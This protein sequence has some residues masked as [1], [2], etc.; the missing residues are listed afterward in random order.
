MGLNAGALFTSLTM[1]VMVSKALSTGEPLSLTRIVT[2]FVL[3]PCASVGVQL[4]RP[5]VGL[6][7]A[8]DGAPGSR[9]KVSNCAGRSGS[10]AAAVK[11]SSDPSLTERLPMGASRG[12]LFTSVTMTV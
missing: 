12:G 5:L 9:L 1:I 2:L 3:G 10:E 11:L 8:P 7:V 6:I 4:N